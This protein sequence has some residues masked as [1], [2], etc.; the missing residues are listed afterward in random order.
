MPQQVTAPAPGL[1]RLPRSESV[2]EPRARR[3]RWRWIVAA[4]L[5]LTAGAVTVLLS[6]LR[7]SY[8]AFGWLVWGR[9][10]LHGHLNTDGAPSWKPLTFLFTL[11]YALVGWSPQM[12]LW[13]I[14]STAGA[15]AA[16]GF[17]GRIAFRLSG[18]AP[19]RPWAP[20]IAAAFAAVGVLGMDDYTHQVMIANSDPLI[21]ALCLAAIDAR[22]AGRRTLPFGLLVLASLGRPEVWAF[23]GAYGAWLL[24]RG[25]SLRGRLLVV[26]ALLVIPL[27]W[28]LVPALTS[29]SW[30]SAGDLALGSPRALHGGKIVGVLDRL[31]NLTAPPLQVAVACALGR[32]VMRRDRRWLALAGLAALWTAIE[33]A[34][35]YHGWSAVP[36]YLMEP[37]AVLIVLAGAML[38]RLLAFSGWGRLRPWATDRP[39]ASVSRAELWA[40][41]RLA[42]VATL[43]PVVL[44]AALLVPSARHR[45]SDVRHEVRV[46][47]HA[48][49]E[50]A[51]LRGVIARV[52]GPDAIKDCGQP[53]TLLGYQS[54]VAWA[55]GLNVGEVGYHPG[56]SI[57]RGVPIVLLKPH[58]DGWQVRPYHSP[59]A[60]AAQCA[61][62]RVDS[63]FGP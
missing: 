3:P 43:V 32:A 12:W 28:F 34:M 39:P 5:V 35:A 63:R 57:A 2:D 30:F 44:V 25:G 18:P 26:L 62:L 10:V 56:R 17:A 51:R 15:F 20:W 29:H 8:D 60:R 49:L 4:V 7:P 48:A 33:I 40:P 38:G 41:V 19:A 9:E 27:G 13:L 23:A 24:W 52:G 14:T 42:S 58:D 22:L 61:R 53:V 6:D 47:R 31:R 11:P 59:P 55:V 1:E 54:A 50:I 37:G 16:A 21:V 46:D 36:R 45:I